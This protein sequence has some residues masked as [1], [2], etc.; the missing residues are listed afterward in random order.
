MA[1]TPPNC[2]ITVDQLRDLTRDQQTAYD[3][4]YARAVAAA[5]RS[6]DLYCGRTFY[7]STTPTA[8]V[9][10][11]EQPDLLWTRDIATSAGL[12]LK[13]DED[14]DGVYETTWTINTDFVLEPF[15]RVQD[16]PYER[17][18]AVGGREFT[19]PTRNRVGRLSSRRPTVQVTAVWGWPDIPASVEQATAIQAVDNF[20]AK[21]LAHVASTYGN[22]VRVARDYSPGMH[23]RKVKFSRTRAPLLNPQAE[24][25]ISALRLTTIA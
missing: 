23:G 13:T 18:A 1:E 8:R 16:N 25:L 22:E 20:K 5:S 19:V 7:R 14:N 6:I 2:Y 17:I 15:E 4:E 9:F 12:L 3:E 21:D 10:R 24:A 11:P